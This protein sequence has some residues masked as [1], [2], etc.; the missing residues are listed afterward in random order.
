MASNGTC[1]LAAPFRSVRVCDAAGAELPRGAVGEL[2]IEG[3]GILWGS[4]KKP[5]A[6]RAS[7]HGNRFRSGVLATMDDNGYVSIV[8]RI[9]ET[10]KRSGE[11]ITANELEAA[12]R[13]H[14]D[15][16]EAAAIGVPDAHRMEEV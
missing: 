3:P 15:V 4:Y 6:N 13:E 12:L 9:K 10:I 14:P 5:R 16:Q 8:G 1:G 2:C 11:N 7:F